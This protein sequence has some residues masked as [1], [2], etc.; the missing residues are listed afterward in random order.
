MSANSEL[1]A[2]ERISKM[3]K[4]ELTEIIK[5]TRRNAAKALLASKPKFVEFTTRGKSKRI[6]VHISMTNHY[7]IKD[8][9]NNNCVLGTRSR[10]ALASEIAEGTG[11][12]FSLK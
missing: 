7:Y 12:F 1:R 5:V 3:S 6:A 2:L 4:D 9:E 8:P 11:D 10:T